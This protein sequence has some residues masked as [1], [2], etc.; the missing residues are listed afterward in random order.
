MVA[1]VVL[2]G[3]GT[4]AAVWGPQLY[5][6]HSYQL[7]PERCTVTWLDVDGADAVDNLTAEQV[8][9]AAIIAAVGTS[10]G[11]D[12]RGV[13]VALATAMQESALRNLDYGDRD[14][15][16]LFQQRPSQGWGTEEQ[17]LDPRYASSMFYQA[18]ERVDGWQDMR[19]TEAAQAV[20]RSGFPEAYEKH[21]ESAFAWAT[22]LTGGGAGIDC[23]VE[24][25]PGSAVDLMDRIALDFG[26]GRYTAQVDQLSGST[27]TLAV[28]AVDASVASEA[29]IREWAIATASTT[30]VTRVE[31]GGQVWRNGSGRSVVAVNADSPTADAVLI[32]VEAP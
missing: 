7:S 20:Q 15:L 3:G 9:N 23:H 10:Y 1:M 17:V 14:S 29:A 12:V 13:T 4:V 21:K 28:R 32:T 2:V 19:L 27:T 30:G 26:S 18:L 24:A 5:Q 6:R 31:F 22:A 25:T 8:D 11:F 16:G